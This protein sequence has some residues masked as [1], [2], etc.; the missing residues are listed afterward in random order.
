M[1]ELS[2]T[3]SMFEIVMQYAEEAKAKKI[4]QI[5]LVIGDMTGIVA[6]C[7]QFYMDFMSK[8]T[9]AEGAKVAVTPVPSQA[10]CRNCQR[11]FKVKQYEWTCPHCGEVSLEITGGKELF[12]FH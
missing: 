8:G 7:V 12:V 5:N 9:I 1:H 2:V 10:K 4:T 3:Q 6:D 11:T